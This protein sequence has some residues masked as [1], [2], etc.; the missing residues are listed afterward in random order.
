MIVFGLALGLESFSKDMKVGTYVIIIGATLLPEVGPQVQANQDIMDLIGKPYSLVWL[1]LLIFTMTFMGALMGFLEMKALSQSRRIGLILCARASSFTVNLTVSRVMALRPNVAYL[2]ISIVL[3]I[4]SGAAMTWAIV[5]QSTAVSQAIYVPLNASALILINA[6]TGV[7]IWED[8]RDV[9]SWLGYV[10][11]FVLLL[12]GNYLLLGDF[13]LFSV[14]NS[15]YGLKGTLRALMRRK[16][17]IVNLVRGDRTASEGSGRVM[18]ERGILRSLSLTA[19]RTDDFTS[20]PGGQ[21]A[22]EVPGLGPSEVSA[23]D[24]EG[25]TSAEMHWTVMA[26]RAGWVAPRDDGQIMKTVAEV[27]FSESS[28]AAVSSCHRKLEAVQSSRNSLTHQRVGGTIN[29]DSVAASSLD[30]GGGR[31]RCVAAPSS[32]GAFPPSPRSDAREDGD[33]R[34]IG[35]R[36]QREFEMMTDNSSSVPTSATMLSRSGVGCGSGEAAWAAV[37]GL[38]DPLHAHGGHT[39][40]QHIFTVD[41]HED[42]T[43]CRGGDAKQHLGL[44]KGLAGGCRR[45]SYPINRDLGDA[46]AGGEEGRLSPARA[47][48]VLG[49]NRQ[50]VVAGLDQR[51]HKSSPPTVMARGGRVGNGSGRMDP[52]PFAKIGVGTYGDYNGGTVSFDSDV[53]ERG[54]GFLNKNARTFVH[55]N[56]GGRSS[57][58]PVAPLS[59]TGLLM[60]SLDSV[61]PSV[62]DPPGDDDSDPNIDDDDRRPSVKRGKCWSPRQWTVFAFLLATAV[63]AA[64]VWALVAFRD[65][66]GE[67][68]PPAGES[69]WGRVLSATNRS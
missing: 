39:R 7:I 1:G 33:S 61:V 4:L 59:A 44:L 64:T 49:L 55:H 8:W 9:G 32:C 62:S 5:V 48:R 13:E 19:D 31:V 20:E 66:G 53:L 24:S 52:V 45:N 11:V 38:D 41:H 12:L 6:L 3:K 28:G 57:S 46:H 50:H 67:E 18:D 37:Y 15:R 30:G 29:L 16:R 42:G 58:D 36:G 56:C 65:A 43:W 25:E 17:K 34:V 69:E 35:G 23:V 60:S 40:E 14:E 21:E 51:Q 2:A 54:G 10:C 27:G 26:A 22:Q 63:T 47:L 68:N